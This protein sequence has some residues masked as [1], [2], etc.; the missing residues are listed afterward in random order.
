MVK[1][2]FLAASTFIFVSGPSVKTF[3]TTESLPRE[4]KASAQPKIQAAIL[5]DVSGSM[6]GLIEQAKA[7][8]WNMVSVMGRVKCDNGTPNIEIALY[9]YGRSDNEASAGYIK[10]IS[11]F[12]TDLDKLSAKLFELKTNGGSEYCGQVIFRSLDELNWDT[13]SSNYKVIFIAGNE[14]FLQGSIHYTKAC[15]D[16]QKKGVI[17]NTIYCGPREQGIREHWNLGGECGQGSYTNIDHNARMEEIPTPYDSVLFA[18]NDRL[19]KTYIYFGASGQVAKN[20]QSRMDKA[21]AEV[22]VSAGLK[23]VKVK[24]HSNLYSNAQWDLVDAIKADSTILTKLDKKT[25]PASLKDKSTAELNEIVKLNAI[26]RGQI[27]QQIASASME[28][29]KFIASEKL[30]GRT[31]NKATLETEIER[32]IRDQVKRFNFQMD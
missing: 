5:L 15:H 29:E 30:K 7:Q 22:S 1:L 9:E 13:A 28:R 21:N 16:A 31:E 3:N 32:I 12:T 27:Q 18:L 8:L 25:L 26:A 20:E 14:D 2:A 24:G 10:L 19:N 23:R 6:Q 11:P 17:V 4:I